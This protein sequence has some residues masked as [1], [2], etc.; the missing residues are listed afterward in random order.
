MAHSKRPI[1]DEM[2]QIEARRETAALSVY[3]FM[4]APAEPICPDCGV[5]ELTRVSTASKGKPERRMAAI[6]PVAGGT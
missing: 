2:R 5:A 6:G 1:R 3:T 4:R